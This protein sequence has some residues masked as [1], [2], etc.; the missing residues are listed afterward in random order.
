VRRKLSAVPETRDAAARRGGATVEVKHTQNSRVNS[1]AAKVGKDVRKGAVLLVY[2]DFGG[3]AAAG[4]GARAIRQ[5]QGSGSDAGTDRA[6]KVLGEARVDLERA[7]AAVANSEGVARRTAVVSQVLAEPG[8]TRGQ[9]DDR[10]CDV[11]GGTE[12]APPQMEG[13]FKVPVDK[14]AKFKDGATVTVFIGTRDSVGLCE[15]AE[16]AADGISGH[17]RAGQRPCRGKRWQHRP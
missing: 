6:R 17:R 4:D 11:R 1:V 5:H 2:D 15:S 13:Q 3:A 10:H 9:R 14:E 12:A 7:Q 8:K 16:K